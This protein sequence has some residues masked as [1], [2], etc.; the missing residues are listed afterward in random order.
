MIEKYIQ[1]IRGFEEMNQTISGLSTQ[2]LDAKGALL[3]AQ[4]KLDRLRQVEM[5]NIT[6]EVDIK[7][8]PT[9]SNAEMRQAELSNRLQTNQEFSELARFKKEKDR[10]I[11]GREIEKAEMLRRWE[12]MM[13]LAR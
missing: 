4:E 3:D 13:H 11:D 1:V 5:F 8:K 12:M 2:I 6:Q 9:F 7:G 10:F